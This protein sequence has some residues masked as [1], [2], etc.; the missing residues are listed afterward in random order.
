MTSTP[1]VHAHELD[2]LLL[3][4]LRKHVFP[5]AVCAVGRLGSSRAGATSS[6]RFTGRAGRLAPN[7]AQV[8]LDTPYDLASLTKP[9]VAVAALRLAQRGALDLQE[10]V[11]RFLP[12]LE[13]THGGDSSLALLLSHRAG[14]AAW[15]GLY[16]ELDAPAGSAEMKRFMLHAAATRVAEHWRAGQSLYSDLGYMIAG[17]A[18]AR[19]AGAPLE[20][21]VRS[22]VTAPLGLDTQLFYPA[23]LPATE[24]R[25]LA[26]RVAPTELCGFR[27]RVMRGEVHDENCY[28]LGGVAGHAGVFGTADAVLSFGLAVLSAL[29]G[30][31]RWLDQALLR[32]ALASRGEGH[33]IGWDTKS[34]EGSSA[35]E[36]FSDRSFGHLGFT[37]TSI[38]CDPT[39]RLCAVLLSNRVHPTRENIAIRAFRPRF[40]D[41][42]A[43]LAFSQGA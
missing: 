40:H 14:L 15:S 9:L 24:R 11:W 32:W 18:I 17:E 31:S 28:A 34:A 5:G 41:A 39:R 1:E 42:M 30:R 35:G 2:A 10:P 27:Q 16:K 37:G 36:Q 12:E 25:E 38:W 23:S 21:V 43:E 19:A 26:T 33:V 8:Q 13:H 6:V 29:E 22:E 3:L 4:G 20:Q 7:E